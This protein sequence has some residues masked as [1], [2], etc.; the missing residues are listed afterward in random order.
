[1]RNICNVFV[2]NI[3]SKWMLL[4]RE[5]SLFVN[6]YSKISWASHKE[7]YKTH[8]G[9]AWVDVHTCMQVEEKINNVEKIYYQPSQTEKIFTVWVLYDCI[10]KFHL[11]AF[12]Q[13]VQKTVLRDLVPP[14]LFS[15]PHTYISNISGNRSFLFFSNFVSIKKNLITMIF[16]FLSHGV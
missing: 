6:I 10:C 4:Y 3:F 2:I 12:P 13:Q 9:R 15:R 14:F 8:N 11:Y 5:R 16:F 1:M 7:T